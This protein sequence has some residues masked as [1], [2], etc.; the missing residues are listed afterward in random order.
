MYGVLGG[1]VRDDVDI[2]VAVVLES[3]AHVLVGSKWSSPWANFSTEDGAWSSSKKTYQRGRCYGGG[4][5]L[6]KYS[7]DKAIREALAALIALWR[8]LAK[9]L[10][11]LKAPQRS[12]LLL[13]SNPDVPMIVGRRRG[14]S[15]AIGP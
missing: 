9:R 10:T 14:P 4:A 6:M 13:L 3:D 8:R 12:A 7:H 5:C 15:E 1:W 2:L 11:F